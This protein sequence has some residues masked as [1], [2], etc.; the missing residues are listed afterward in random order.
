MRRAYASVAAG[1]ALLLVGCSSEVERGRFKVTV[2]LEVEGQQKIA[3][4]VLELV[5][6]SNVAPN[7]TFHVIGVSP[8]FELGNGGVLIV[9]LKSS[10]GPY[11]LSALGLIRVSLEPPDANYGDFSYISNASG[12]KELPAPFYPALEY[13]SEDAADPSAIIR[14]EPGTGVLGEKIRHVRTIIQPTNEKLITLVQDPPSWLVR[15]RDHLKKIS[16][17]T[18]AQ[19]A[20][21]WPPIESANDGSTP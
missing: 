9:P 2:E 17:K 16:E 18:S 12:T 6:R 14:V 8:I 5:V 21:G 3:S 7:H 10:W 1:L 4:S 11:A 19:R 13:I 20:V 15:M